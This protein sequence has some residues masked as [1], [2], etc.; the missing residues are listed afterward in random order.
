MKK[1]LAG[2]VATA[3]ALMFSVLSAPPSQ[4]ASQPL[5]IDFSTTTGD[6]RGGASGT[7]Y[8][9][10]DE[11]APTQALINGAHI[12][13]TSQKPPYGTQHPGG[14]TLKIEDG[15]FAKHGE[16]LYIYAQDYYPEWPYNSGERPGDERTYDLAKG[17]Y[18]EGPNG[19]WDYLEV[20]EF[21]V[22]AVATR[23]E[24][25]EKYVIIPF[26]EADGGNWYPDWATQKD[27]FL[28]DWEA[29]YNEI[30][31][32]YARHGLGHARVGG[33]GDSRWL[34]QRSSD[35]VAFAK[36][37]K[38]LPDIWIWHE[39]GIENL[40]TYRGHLAEYRALEQEHG[41]GPLPVNITEYGMLRD[42]GT[43]GQLVQWFSMFEDTKVDAQ[44]AYW[45]YSGN[46]S[47]NTARPNGANAGWWLFKWYG[48]LEGSQTV[49]VTAPQPDTADTLQAIAA[50]DDTNSRATVLLGGS[51]DDVA[52]Q[53]SG[54]DRKT[55]GAS[56]DIEVREVATTGAEGLAQTPRVVWAK[57]AV[58]LNSGALNLPV[59]TYN[60]YAAY[61][62]IITPS[63][64]R[65]VAK[66]YAAQPWT[67]T[68]EA[69]DT[70]VTGADITTHDPQASGGWTWLA[71]GNKDVRAFKTLD[72]RS[73]WTVKVPRTGAYRLQVIGASNKKPGRHALFVD[74][75]FSKL[76]QYAADLHW[77]Y[78]GSAEVLLDLKAGTH[79]LSLRTSQDG[80]TLLPNPDV[81]LDRYLLTDVTDG[82]PTQYPASTFRLYNGAKLDHGQ[83]SLSG[84]ARSD[85]YVTAMDTG[86][87][88]VD[89]AYRT[90][91]PSDVRVTVNGRE[92]AK[93]SA[94][95][96][97]SWKSTVRLRLVEGI[98]EIEL[99]SP[100]GVLI[101][102]L[103][104]TRVR[105]SDASQVVLEA[106]DA[107]LEG[108]ASVTELAAS[109]GSNASGRGYVGYVGNGTENAVVFDRVKGYDQPGDYDVAITYANAELKGDHQY[110]PQVVDRRAE[111]QEGTRPIGHGYFRYTYDW[112]SF[113][114]RSIAVT[115]KTANQPLRLT[116]SQG[117]AP[118]ID[119]V[120]VAPAVLGS[121][122]TQRLR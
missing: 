96:S 103:T 6:F 19:V 71:S 109:V 23:S 41:I 80:K 44:T 17:T 104:T 28:G 52:L 9:F 106:E 57:N 48:D 83:A 105:K 85:L 62:V 12:T 68:V 99:R 102:T 87:Y 42:M 75:R 56:V 108:Q 118:N 49:K 94:K 79:T 40:A 37:R 90:K 100:S 115:L 27:Q 7:L 14:D 26:N 15:F 2:V 55:F 10:G 84:K 45:G 32:V 36:D 47:D 97:G 67:T 110:N 43:P 54:L 11:G 21:V 112:N 92:R 63:G 78:R 53:L 3:A 89:V 20:L 61:Q 51:D 82:E 122:L 120:T 64:D 117:W 18:T 33:P 107:R 88:D 77:D 72:S 50:R 114:Q 24:H 46:F 34:K 1:S 69:E 5:K 111:L 95:Q 8:G 30:Q 73:D 31:E 22:E 98:N 59:Q 60:R 101:D 35:F 65:D 29:T 39:L 91:K 4:A 121:P 116:S 76:V 81:T 13:N 119:K 93:L 58:K 113:S 86:Y 66:A 74:D 38:V 25:P 70:K 16:D